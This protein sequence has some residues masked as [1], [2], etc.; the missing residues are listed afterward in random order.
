MELF[1][2]P[3]QEENG[4]LFVGARRAKREKKKIHQGNEWHYLVLFSYF[5]KFLSCRMRKAGLKE[6]DCTCT[7]QIYSYIWL[8]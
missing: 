3:S 4:L 2:N 6:S 5:T 8:Y 7:A 1:T